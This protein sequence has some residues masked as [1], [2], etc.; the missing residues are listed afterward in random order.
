MAKIHAMLELT[1]FPETGRFQRRHRLPAASGEMRRHID[2]HGGARNSGVNSHRETANQRVRHAGSLQ[3]M[4][5]VD[6]GGQ[7]VR[8]RLHISRDKTR[9]AVAH[10]R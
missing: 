10:G 5:R 4:H 6:Q 3:C 8:L 7:L 2:V 9:S 1:R